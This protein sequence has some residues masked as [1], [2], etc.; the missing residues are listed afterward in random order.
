MPLFFAE[1]AMYQ[2]SAAVQSAVVDST[3]L[4]GHARPAKAHASAQVFPGLA[5]PSS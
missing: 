5:L 4:L 2:S 3:T 1:L